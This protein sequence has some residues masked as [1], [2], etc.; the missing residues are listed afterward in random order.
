[1]IS[2]KDKFHNQQVLL[3]IEVPMGKKIRLSEEVDNYTWFNI[4][5][6]GGYHISSYTG[7]DDYETGRQYIMTQSGLKRERD[8]TRMK[9]RSD[10]DEDDDDD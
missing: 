8:T 4:S 1:M 2:S 6:S 5:S 3:T 9:L 10:V 7:D